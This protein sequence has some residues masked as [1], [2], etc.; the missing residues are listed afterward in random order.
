MSFTI[1]LE[2]TWYDAYKK[3][4]ELERVQQA[5]DA[6]LPAGTSVDWEA[7]L[8]ANTIDTH[9]VTFA[10]NETEV[11]AD[12]LTLLTG[13]FHLAFGDHIEIVPVPIAAHRIVLEPDHPG[14]K[15]YSAYRVLQKWENEGEWFIAEQEQ[16]EAAYHTSTK[17]QMPIDYLL[18][19]AH[20]RVSIVRLAQHALQRQVPVVFHWWPAT[21]RP[22]A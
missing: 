5:I 20:A 9:T 14:W 16:L 11:L 19:Q 12:A 3:P 17:A 21:P 2:Y 13:D 4:D 8:A 22:D 7:L 10:N 6:N 15:L 1:G 18:S